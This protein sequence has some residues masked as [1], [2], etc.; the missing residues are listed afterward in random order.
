MHTICSVF[1][2]LF[3]PLLSSPLLL[4]SLHPK[5]LFISPQRSLIVSFVFCSLKPSLFHQAAFQQTFPPGESFM[6][7]ALGKQHLAKGISFMLVFLKCEMRCLIFDG[8]WHFPSLRAHAFSEEVTSQTL[9]LAFWPVKER[10]RVCGATHV[11]FL[12]S[13]SSCLAGGHSQ[14][15]VQGRW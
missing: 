8:D 12:P 15:M 14:G 4:P 5:S 6:V 3:L 2:L 10:F 1:C 7:V 11:P 9:D 13:V